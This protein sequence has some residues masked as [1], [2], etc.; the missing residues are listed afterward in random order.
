[1]QLNCPGALMCCVAE[2]PR[3][4]DIP[5]ISDCRSWS[6]SSV[7]STKPAATEKRPKYAP[8]SSASSIGVAGGFSRERT[9][10]APTVFGRSSTRHL[11][12]IRLRTRFGRRPTR[13]NAKTRRMQAGNVATAVTHAKN[14]NRSSNSKERRKELEQEELEILSYWIQAFCCEIDGHAWYAYNEKWFDVNNYCCTFVK[15]CIYYIELDL[16]Y[17]FIAD[18]AVRLRVQTCCMT[19]IFR[20]L[21]GN[22]SNTTA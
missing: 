8:T 22:E 18:Y 15:A 21:L 5:G 6:N 4:R 12:E 16:I 10:K 13:R 19:S 3:S 20:S 2:V 17:I 14:R 11:R 7:P 9:T 1:M